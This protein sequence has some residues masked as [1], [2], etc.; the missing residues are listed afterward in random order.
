MKNYD[1]KKLTL[2]EKCALLTGAN[3]WQTDGA[4]GK[5]KT[6]WVSDGPSGLRMHNPEKQEETFTATA[7]PTCHVLANTWNLKL[8]YEYG[9][10]IADECIYRG[11][12]VLL[13]PGVNIKRTPLCGRNFEYF[14]ED[15]Y[16]SGKFAVEYVKGLQDKGIGTS[17]KH[18]CA[19]NSEYDRCHQSSEVDERALHEV[20]LKP[21]EMAMEAKPWTVMCSYN[22]VN[23]VYASE[24]KKLLDTVLRGQFGFDGLIMSDWGAV[25]NPVRAV[26]ATLDLCM[27]HDDGYAGKACGGGEEWETYRKAD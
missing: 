4:N 27:P 15:P 6:V 3:G 25:H 21:F 19:N 22:P 17:V 20:Y 2:E 1:L 8:A 18:Y 5:V 10:T 16:L 24:N 14:S 7:M 26:E 23:G 9:A 12:D 13:A 11:A